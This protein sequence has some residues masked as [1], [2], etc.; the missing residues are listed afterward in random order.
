MT[1][2]AR[3]RSAHLP[4]VARMIGLAK[5]AHTMQRFVYRS[6]TGADVPMDA[7][8]ILAFCGAY[9]RAL[10]CVRSVVAAFD[11][12][13]ARM[14]PAGSG[15]Y[16]LRALRCACLHTWSFRKGC[17][18]VRPR[19][20]SG[21]LAGGTAWRAASRFGRTT[22]CACACATGLTGAGIGPQRRIE[23]KPLR[24]EEIRPRSGARPCHP[25]RGIAEQSPVNPTS[26]VR[27][28]VL[29]PRVTCPA[30]RSFG[31]GALSY[32]LGKVADNLRDLFGTETFVG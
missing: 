26:A 8:E 11:M 1:G 2:H 13:L 6:R 5:S 4:L 7:S 9:G 17:V 31:C 22:C 28:R 10:R 24:T 3:G 21:R 32:S 18:P 25:R 19:V 14:E 30:P 27:A 20:W 16:H 23:G 12:P 15:P 29:L